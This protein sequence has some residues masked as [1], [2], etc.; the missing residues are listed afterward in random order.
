MLRQPLWGFGW[1]GCREELSQRGKSEPRTSQAK[2]ERAGSGQRNGTAARL[3]PRFGRQ[4]TQN[5]NFTHSLLTT[6]FMEA[7]VT[8]SNSHNRCGVSR[9]E[10]IPPSAN[11]MEAYGGHVLIKKEKEIQRKKNISCVC[12]AHVVSRV[13][14][15][16]QS[17]LTWNQD[18]STVLE[19]K[20]AS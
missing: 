4:F 7:R 20:T 13:Q 10:K 12:T 18:V 19:A 16:Q 8:F 1:S 5:S 14:K 17:N 15:T 6:T 3:R 11:T 9:K 2:M